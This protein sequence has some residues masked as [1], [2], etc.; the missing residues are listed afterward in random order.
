MLK[1]LVVTVQRH[2]A[3]IFVWDHV[4]MQFVHHDVKLRTAV[5][6]VIMTTGSR[7][8][9]IGCGVHGNGAVGLCLS[10]FVTVNSSVG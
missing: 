2:R 9:Y 10:R 4:P 1:I 5:K 3:R 6:I 7:F 8:F